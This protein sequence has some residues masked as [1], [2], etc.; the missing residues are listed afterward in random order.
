MMLRSVIKKLARHSRRFPG[1]ASQAAQT[2]LVDETRLRELALYAES[3]PW[4]LLAFHRPASHP[5][6]GETLSSHRGRGFE[7]EENRAY[8][9]GDEPRLLNWRLYAR[10]GELYT[11]VFTEERRPQVFLLVDR[12]ASMRF[13]TQRQLKVSLAAEIAACYAWQAWHQALAVGG[14]ILNEAA[15]WFDPA[16]GDVALHALVQSLAAPCPALAFEDSQP[17]F[18]EVLR[19]LMHRLPGGSF[20]LL[21]SDFSDFD[22]GAA[23]P[24]LH[25]LAALHTVQAIQILDPIESRLPESGDFLIE[26]GTA[27][28]PLRIDGRDDLQQTLYTRTFKARQSTLAACFNACGIPF[29]TC[30]TEDDVETCLGQP[31]ADTCID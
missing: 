6:I 24:L 25:Q 29:K 4:S 23:M 9:V 11:K 27:T 31:D 19:L 12:R 22:P 3:L 14:L 8:Q 5:L 21:I 2:P 16:M 18:G 17:D 30:T 20:V 26:D 13:A 28:R 10:T 1:A 15:Q 7:F